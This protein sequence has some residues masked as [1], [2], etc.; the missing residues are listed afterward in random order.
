MRNLR[1]V[2]ITDQKH[3]KFR[4]KDKKES[5]LYKETGGEVSSYMG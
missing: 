2:W 5:T 3:N 1:E 4:T